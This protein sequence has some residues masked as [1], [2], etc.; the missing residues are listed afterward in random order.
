MF[1]DNSIADGACKWEGL[2]FVLVTGY[3]SRSWYFERGDEF[4]PDYEI[5]F[6]TPKTVAALIGRPLED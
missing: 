5:E 2:R 1:G 3:R 6:V 4:T